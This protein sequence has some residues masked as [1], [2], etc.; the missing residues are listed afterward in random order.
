MPADTAAL[1]PPMSSGTA[2][3]PAAA[4]MRA[5]HA[6][7]GG[8]ALM[9]HGAAFV[10][11]IREF[12]TRDAQQLGSVNWFMAV[13]MH[14]LAGG[15][16]RLR[17]MGSAEPFT[18]TGRGYPELLQ[19]ATPYRGVTVSDRQ[20]PHDLLA[21]AAVAYDR[22]LSGGLTLSFYA[23]AVG[24]PALG[25]VAYSHRPSAAYDPIAPLGHHLQD[26]THITNG[27]VTLGVSTRRVKIEGSAF[28]AA[29]GDDVWTDVDPIAL[30]S[31]T[32]RISV[33][34]SAH[35]SIATWVGHLA[36]V[37]GAHAHEALDRF[38]ASVLHTR[39]F[40]RRGGEWSSAFV[41][42][43]DLREGAPHPLNSLLVE[44][45]LELD[46][47]N[48]VFARAEYVRRTSED[49]ALIGSIPEEV[50]IGAVAG[51]YART[52]VRRA[53]ME[54][55]IGL[56]GTMRFVPAELELFYGSRTPVGVLAYLELR[57]AL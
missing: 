18:L 5:V 29:H 30:N 4:P 42:G 57:P 22:S 35:W 25:P 16:V 8:W 54:A 10:Q 19:V 9:V 14:S 38:G 46:R 43:A 20:H 36:A 27:V 39:P 23:A 45:T 49:L 26:L 31:Y 12:G 44:T 53:R 55:V 50:D 47:V 17:A 7:L 13:A 51:G 1:T 40:G 6:T 52:V 15:V 41:Y 11:Y 3:L 34:P 32:G 56:R 33:N 48:A 28:N 21:E 37:G 24:E 2:W